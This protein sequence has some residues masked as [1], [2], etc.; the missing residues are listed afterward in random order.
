MLM[1]GKA[2]K[3]EQVDFIDFDALRKHVS[4]YET[5]FLR[6]LQLLVEQG[7]LWVDEL[8]LAFTCCDC[9]IVRKLC[10]KIKGS[11]G[12]LQAH[13][14]IEAAAELSAHAASGDLSAAGKSRERLV[15][16]INDT[17]AFVKNSGHI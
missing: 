4:G 3:T 6:L 12:T 2:V 17:V 7:P 5:L 9:D 10:H 14:I 16:M 8:D 13:Y 1:V 15:K 11:A